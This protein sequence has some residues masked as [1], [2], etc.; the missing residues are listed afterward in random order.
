MSTSEPREPSNGPEEPAEEFDFVGEIFVGSVPPNVIATFPIRFRLADLPTIPPALPPGCLDGVSWEGD[1]L[2]EN[3]DAISA[4]VREGVVDAVRK[5]GDEMR[6]IDA[7]VAAFERTLRAAYPDSQIEVDLGR[8][9][10]SLDGATLVWTSFGPSD[11]FGDEVVEGAGYRM[12]EHEPRGWRVG[13]VTSFSPADKRHVSDAY[14]SYGRK[15]FRFAWAD[16]PAERKLQT[17]ARLPQLAA[18]IRA[19]LKAGAAALAAVPDMSDAFAAN[20][21]DDAG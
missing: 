18:K 13:I 20:D 10:N 7:S 21:A 1:G 6:R 11:D 9:E 19:A 5:F 15:T 4:E 3:E 12:H 16:A 14:A 8:P 17:A 2:I